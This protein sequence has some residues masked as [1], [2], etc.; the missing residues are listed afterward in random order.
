[1]DPINETQ[2]DGVKNA[3]EA[4]IVAHIASKAAKREIINIEGIPHLVTPKDC[5]IE[6]ME[7]YLPAPHR[8][9]IDVVLR[10]LPDLQ[11]YIEKQRDTDPCNNVVVF[12][13]R[14]D[15]MF[16]AY[17]DYHRLGNDPR[18]LNHKAI[19]KRN[20]SHQFQ[21]WKGQDGKRM[22]Q[23][24]FAEFLDEN[25]NDILSPS[26]ADVVRFASTL[27]AHR[28]ETFKSSVNIANGE[29]KFVWQNESKGDEQ[30][31]FPTE[32]T[33]NI[34]I[35]SGGQNIAIP[36][37]LF[38]RVSEGKLVLWYKLRMIER[39]VDKIFSEEV[40]AMSTALDAI[41]TVYQGKAPRAPTIQ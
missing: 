41:A 29:V 18:W 20:L 40:E 12:A 4:A 7:K 36:V 30:V 8:P 14:D 23:E 19:V 27:E 24:T 16:T 6:S 28:T 33:L 2:F 32:M 37:K 11:S 22:A 13:D 35:W 1:M 10:T 39:I 21:A 17:L 26:G 9:S 15:L 31:Q 5:E 3:P 34:P 25:V 38:Y